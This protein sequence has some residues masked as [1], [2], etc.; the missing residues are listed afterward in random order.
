MNTV[1]K[2]ALIAALASAFKPKFL[3]SNINDDSS[4]GTFKPM[5]SDGA[6][7]IFA[8][9]SAESKFTAV[10]GIEHDN[11]DI[12]FEMAF[13]GCTYNEELAQ[14]E[15]DGVDCESTFGEYENNILYAK[16]ENPD[17]AI[18][19]EYQETEG[20][21]DLCDKEVSVAVLKTIFDAMD[22]NA[23]YEFN[24]AVFEQVKTAT[25]APS[26]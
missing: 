7:I 16:G 13:D 18:W 17:F 4:I 8:A 1:Q 26:E 22:A 12:S 10:D 24:M 19:Q 5:E 21:D 14:Y 6:Y 23:R 25:D 9:V 11:A 3:A 15:W 20:A 2:Q